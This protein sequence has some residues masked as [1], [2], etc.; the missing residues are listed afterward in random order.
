MFYAARMKKASEL[1]ADTSI[2]TIDQWMRGDDHLNRLFVSFEFRRLHQNAVGRDNDDDDDNNNSDDSDSDDSDEH[3][4]LPTESATHTA[5]RKTTENVAFISGALVGTGAQAVNGVFS[6]ST[7]ALKYAG[8][9]V[10]SSLSK[11]ADTVA[12]ARE[13][14]L[15]R[16]KRK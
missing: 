12:Q 1:P 9:I 8:S 2:A 15:A 7:S 6:N 11:T 13:K 3:V 5:L 16:V 4:S 14:M 10:G